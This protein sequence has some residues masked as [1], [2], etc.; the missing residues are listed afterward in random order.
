LPIAE[1]GCC[2]P[3]PAAAPDDAAFHDRL[4]ELLRRYDVNDYAASVRVFALKP[5]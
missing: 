2:S 4:A 5:A 3:A 1:A